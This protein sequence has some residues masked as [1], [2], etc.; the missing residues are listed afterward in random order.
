LELSLREALSLGH[1][2]I[3]PEHVLLGLVRERDGVA[4]QVLVGLGAD[5]TAI[6]AA[7]LPLLPR[8]EAGPQIPRASQPQPEIVSSDRVIRRLLAAAGGR[9]VGDGRTELGLRDLLASVAE[10]EE[11]ARA[12]ASLGV[13]V[14]AMREA[15]ERGG[16]PEE[17][18]G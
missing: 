7:V 15:I 4:T 18:A 12:L 5:E 9:A 8:V 2:K 10:D 11:A 13:D 3:T 1:R 6:R 16:T 14:E 17:P